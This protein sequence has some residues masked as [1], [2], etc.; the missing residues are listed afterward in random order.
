MAAPYNPPKKN[1]DFAI[2]ISLQDVNIS[3]RFISAPVIASGDFM[4]SVDGAAFASVNTLPFV[5][6]SGSIALR[7]TLSASEMNG[8]VIAVKGVDVSTPALWADFFLAI[9]TTA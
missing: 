1:E 8:D 6:P 2:A 4:V 9:P 7:L 5:S 3:G